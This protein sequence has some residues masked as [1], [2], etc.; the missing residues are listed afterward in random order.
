MSNRG[1]QDVIVGDRM[2]VDQQFAQRVSD[3]EFSR[4][5]WGL[6]M[7]AVE[8]EIEN[9][10]DEERARIVAETSKI[11]QVMPELDN[12]RDQMGAIG[13]GGGGG[14]SKGGGGIFDSVKDALGLGGG[15][16]GADDERLRA[17]ERL[18]QEYADELQQHLESSGKWEQV[19]RTASE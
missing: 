7:T 11:E 12:I 19:R 10:D 15:A 18:T 14:P 1:W 5:E 16:G 6:I 3:S 8:F 2:T 13:A 9:P 17:A 4:Q